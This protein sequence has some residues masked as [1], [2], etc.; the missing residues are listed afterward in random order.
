MCRKNASFSVSTALLCVSKEGD[1]LYEGADMGILVSR[2]RMM[3]DDF[4]LN[5][6]AKKWISAIRG[7][8]SS[9]VIEDRREKIVLSGSLTK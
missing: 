8:Y 4:K 9:Q 2:G 5:A 7:K 3:T 1:Y 6:R